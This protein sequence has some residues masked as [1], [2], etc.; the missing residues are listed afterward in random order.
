MDGQVRENQLGKGAWLPR[1]LRNESE[2]AARENR[3]VPSSIT[4]STFP[5]NEC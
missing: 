2:L 4:N 1:A 3:F 5:P